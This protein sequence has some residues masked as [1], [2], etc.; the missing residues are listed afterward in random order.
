MV[1]WHNPYQ[2]Y[3]FNIKDMQVLNYDDL[4]YVMVII[5]VTLNLLC[6]H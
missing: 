6:H 3:M 1:Y 5:S 2:E 4:D